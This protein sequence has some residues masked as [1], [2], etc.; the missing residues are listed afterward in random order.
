MKDLRNEVI[1]L[2]KSLRTIR[3]VYRTPKLYDIYHKTEREKVSEKEINKAD[4]AAH[5]TLR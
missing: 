5:L 3:A 1:L 4:K 2:K